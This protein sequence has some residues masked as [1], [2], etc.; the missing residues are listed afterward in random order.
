MYVK[1]MNLSWTYIRT[2]EAV[3]TTGSLSAAARQLGLTQPTAGRHIDLLET[4]L[5]AP[6]FRRGRDGMILTPQAESLIGDA[7]EMLTAATAFE[8]HAAG[9]EEEIS[10]VVRISANEIFGAILLPRMLPAFLRANPSIE[11][12]VSVSN[13][14]ANLL[15]RDADIALRMFRPTQNDLLARKLGQIPLGLYASKDY[16]AFAGTPQKLEDLRE[17]LMIGFDR[18]DSMIAFAA[19]LGLTMERSDF[20]F[21]S[22]SLLAQIEA[23]KAGGGIGVTHQGLAQGWPG[24][25]Q[26]LPEVALRPLDLWMASHVDMRTN[27]RVR[28]VMEYLAQALRTP[29]AS[30]QS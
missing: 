8:R 28:L 25:K 5:N 18:D 24:V 1:F 3:A 15:Q 6:L 13:S 16:L 26:V 21:R 7:R 14:S 12:E 17:H 29:F 4:A 30:A 2:F 19:A 23:I 22:D 11:I 9:L 10:G 27:K 20:G